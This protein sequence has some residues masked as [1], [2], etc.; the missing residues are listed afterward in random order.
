MLKLPCVRIYFKSIF[1]FV[2]FMLGTIA[3][4]V[5][6]PNGE[7]VRPPRLIA[8]ADAEPLVREPEVLP[9]ESVVI[10]PTPITP[11]P[12]T[13]AP[14]EPSPE[15]AELTVVA[16]TEGAVL[17]NDRLADI[18]V[19]SDA[20]ANEPFL[21]TTILAY[22]AGGGDK[23]LIASGR[24][25][26]NPGSD[27]IALTWDIRDLAPGK[28]VVRI[29]SQYGPYHLQAEVPVEI[30]EPPQIR[31]TLSDLRRDG[32]AFQATFVA[33]AAPSRGAEIE[34]Y[35]WRPHDGQAMVTRD[36]K[37]TFEFF[38]P[39]RSYGLTVD[40]HDSDGGSNSFTASID[41]PRLAIE[42]FD[43]PFLFMQARR[44]FCGCDSMEVR[45]N[46]A[47]RT[48]TYCAP[49]AAAVP[50][51]GCAQVAAP[52]ACP[53][54]Q[55]A[56]SCQLGPQDPGG[57]PGA[58][59]RVGFTFEAVATLIKGSTPALCD[60]GQVAQGNVAIN[61]VIVGNGPTAAAPAGPN[62]TLQRAPGP[63]R[64]VPVVNAPA[65]YPNAA[66]AN[67]GA[68]NYT[69]PFRAK[70]HNGNFVMWIDIPSLPVNAG[71]NRIVDNRAYISFVGTLARGQCWCE[72]DINQRWRRGAGVVNGPGAVLV[73][74]FK[75][76]LN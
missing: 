38:G 33:K 30:R 75:C 16:P 54:A 53:G 28:Y 60:E 9:G 26:E 36:P 55:V 46:A 49:N 22:P 58:N 12:I 29:E 73:D 35:I 56:Y 11:A 43:E 25:R 2:A 70:R 76:K 65:A 57:N 72:I 64:V 19:R 74:G 39:G 40:V 44:P 59:A 48:A 63:N 23:N 32:D 17:F 10:A 52:G 67:W 51:P 21:E 5:A 14:A 8:P 71:F 61:N 6:Q 3:S 1:L 27:T 24:L 15:R 47:N 18:I 34:R 4:G 62:V 66:A 69:A 20:L 41:L 42:V 31:V 68:D 7:E 37:A 13:P 45:V 50:G